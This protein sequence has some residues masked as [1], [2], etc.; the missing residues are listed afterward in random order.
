MIIGWIAL[1][2]FKYRY[3]NSYKQYG[4]SKSCVLV[5]KTTYLIDE[6]QSIKGNLLIDLKN[7]SEF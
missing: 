7:I 6:R 5:F 2:D 3:N 1:I 4:F